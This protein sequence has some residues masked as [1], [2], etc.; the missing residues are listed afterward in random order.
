MLE[1]KLGDKELKIKFSYEATVRSGIITK[2]VELGDLESGG[3]SSEHV[4]HLLELLPEMLL[5][6]AQKYHREEFGYDYDTGN[7]KEAAK[8]NMYSLLD[9]FLDEEGSD[10]MGLFASLQKEMLSNGF[11]AQLYRQEKGAEPAGKN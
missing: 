2:L 7:G 9:D 3:K 6:G 1:I 4:Q 11:L 5:V 10:F 8:S